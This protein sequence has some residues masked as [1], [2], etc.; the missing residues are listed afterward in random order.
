D[1]ASVTGLQDGDVVAERLA[2][3][4]PVGFL[5]WPV[6]ALLGVLIGSAFERDDHDLATDATTAWV[7]E[8]RS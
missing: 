7:D 3:T 5:S 8:I 2:V 6:G 1:P 4:S